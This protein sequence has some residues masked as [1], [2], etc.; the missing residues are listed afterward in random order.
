MTI[1]NTISDIIRDIIPG[2]PD[3]LEVAEQ[4]TPEITVEQVVTFSDGQKQNPEP[5]KQ[6]EYKRPQRLADFIGNSE[7]REQLQTTV[8][9]IKKMNRRL[10]NIIFFGSAG[11]GKCITTD[12][13]VFTTK[14][15]K[16]IGELGN[17]KKSGFQEKVLSVFSLNSIEETSHFYNSGI[18]ETIKIKSAYGF[19]I[20][21]TKNHRIMTCNENGGLEMI[22]LSDI[23]TGHSVAIGRGQNVWGN[24]IN[25]KEFSFKP[26][27]HNHT[28]YSETRIPTLLTKE[29]CWFLG[30]LIGDGTIT[31]KNTIQFTSA[32]E[33]L[34]KKY[35]NVSF[36]LF[37]CKHYISKDKRSSA[38]NIRISNRKIRDFLKHI[39]LNYSDSNTKKIPEIILNTT[40]ENIVEFIKAY[41]DC[42]GYMERNGTFISITSA[43]RKM[44]QQLHLVLLNFGIVSS[45]KGRNKKITT[46]KRTYYKMYYFLDICGRDRD[47]FM[48]EIGFSLTRKKILWKEKEF[49]TYNSN[50][51]T[52]PYG[53]N[54]LK[55]FRKEVNNIMSS[56]GSLSTLNNLRKAKNITISKFNQQITVMETAMNDVTKS[57]NELKKIKRDY[58]F[59]DKVVE[60]N[61]S[62]SHVVDLSIPTNHL[63]FANGFI[64]HNTTL[65]KIL[66]NEVDQPCITITGNSI[67][68]QEDLMK[69]IFRMNEAY[70][71]TGKNPIL[72]IDEIGSISFSKDLDQTI[73]LPLIEDF[74]FY[75]NLEN[76]I[77][78][79]KSH[80]YEILT[81]EYKVPEFTVIGATTDIA[82][83]NPAL[84]RRF[85]LH[86]FMKPYTPEELQKILLQYSGKK[87][88]PLTEPAALNIAKRSRFT[89]ATA[90]SYL[91]A[92]EYYQVGNSLPEIND[93][94]V[95]R[96]MA[97]QKIDSNGLKWED[98]EVL[99]T[100]A[101]F[102]KGMGLKNLASAAGISTDVVEEIV[103]PFLKS[104]KLMAV[105][106]KRII[107]Q[108]GL[109]YIQKGEN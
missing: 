81:G 21:G 86:F 99:R 20:E 2:R 71:E 34:I 109:E 107:T 74:V 46:T 3:G 72:F 38:V 44:I 23:K 33:E 55:K 83:L 42:D 35:I 49:P 15:I 54:L 45:F 5:E 87:N 41:F 40:K 88:I 69:I 14:G 8:Q 37:N 48:Q 6:Q 58:I 64:N 108:K 80:S 65:A 29:L 60:K 19:E 30:L 73:W 36:N 106:N 50:R 1:M 31:D 56:W 105:I 79:Y 96:Q 52:I 22:K 57:F 104:C 97:V 92:C 94:V 53:N 25:I 61:N 28:D 10:P 66:G 13:Y 78:D 77:I 18:Q 101:E 39:G 85:P 95:N 91:E 51:D 16:T 9:A 89:P 100:L 11:T 90:L 67:N 98:M 84:R 7:I 26:C 47:L 12:S 76:K 102:P 17:L 70:D 27:N 59:W 82:N 62:C 63:F 43:S 93:E 32:D 75:N 68:K 24:T 103:E 4:I